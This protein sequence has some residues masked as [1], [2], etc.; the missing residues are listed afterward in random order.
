MKICSKCKIEKDFTA[1]YKE[2]SVSDGFSRWCKD[3]RREYRQ[4]PGQKEYDQ[5]YQKTP[6]GRAAYQRYNHKIEH[7]HSQRKYKYGISQLEFDNILLSQE[8]KCAV[9]KKD[10]LESQRW[11]VD[12][13]HACCP[14]RRSCGKCIR[15]ILCNNCNVGIGCL[16]DDIDTIK[17]AIKYLSRSV[18]YS[19]FKGPND[20][21]NGLLHCN[22][23][24]VEN[25]YKTYQRECRIKKHCISLEQYNLM[26]LFQNNQCA[27]CNTK[28]PRK[29]QNES[30]NFYIDHDHACCPGAFSCGQCVR[31]LL[32]QLCNS[33]I[34]FFNDSLQTLENAIQY[35]QNPI[36][37]LR[38]G[39]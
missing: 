38:I 3:C 9:C 30:N 17:M 21:K 15:G 6:E 8:N 11:Y 36:H 2:K 23:K 27:I 5:K 26:L 28:K 14:G 1:F 37:Q 7:R 25:G 12:H 22:I 4:T 18:D 10:K 24:K 33:G 31:G 39:L 34:G 19:S 35:L 32:C 13:D 16:K 20:N 29:K